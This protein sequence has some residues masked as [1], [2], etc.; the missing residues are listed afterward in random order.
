LTIAGAV[1]F[2]ALLEVVKA[3]QYGTFENPDPTLF[4][5]L[6]RVWSISAFLTPGILIVLLARRRAPLLSAVTYSFGGA[7]NY[8]YHYGE[9]EGQGRSF[10]DFLPRPHLWLNTFEGLLL[11]AA[12]GAIVGFVMVFLKRRLTSGSSGRA[13]RLR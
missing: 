10:T 2:Y 9:W 4:A 3:A 1:V 6:W 8:L 7:A 12:I 11:Y 13:D 5:R